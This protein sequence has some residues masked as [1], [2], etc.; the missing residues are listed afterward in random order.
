[1]KVNGGQN[2]FTIDQFLWMCVHCSLYNLAKLWKFDKSGITVSLH[3]GIDA[4]FGLIESVPR[5]RANVTH[6]VGLCCV[7]YVDLQWSDKVSK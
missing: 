2:I 5:G 3:E 1:M 7:I 6:Y 4:C